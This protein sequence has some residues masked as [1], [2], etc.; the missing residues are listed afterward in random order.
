M[1]PLRAHN[2]LVL[3]SE[4]L[5]V[6][7]SSGSRRLIFIM[8]T[9]VFGAALIFGF[10]PARDL[11]GSRLIGTVI[12][13]IVMLVLAGVVAWS[14]EVR[15]D[16][17]KARIETAY[18]VFGFEVKQDPSIP[19]YGIRSVVLQKVQLLQ[20]RDI[21]LKKS[22]TLGGLMEARAQLFRLFLDAGDGRLKLDESNYSDQL[23]DCA[24]MISEFIGVE[25]ISDEI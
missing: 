19:F 8:L 16:G 7:T 23:A 24:K 4:T 10:D 3:K 22:G 18:R 14:K 2:R 6:L 1:T 5:L 13:G 9:A 11:I 15:F 21:P 25:L 17:S 12:Y 20:H